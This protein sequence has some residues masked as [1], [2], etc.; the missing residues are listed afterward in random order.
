MLFWVY[1]TLEERRFSFE[2][3]MNSF[4]KSFKRS[5]ILFITTELYHTQ[6][7]SDRSLVPPHQ[8]CRNT[9]HCPCTSH[10]AHRFLRSYKA[11][12]LVLPTI[13]FMLH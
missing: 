8:A 10:S 12:I 13:S 5:F 9:G 11:C 6:R 4:K 1:W 3:K 7:R 2:I